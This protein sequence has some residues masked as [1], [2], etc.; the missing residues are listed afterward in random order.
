M[1]VADILAVVAG[2]FRG[3]K[4]CLCIGFLHIRAV[5]GELAHEVFALLKRQIA[6]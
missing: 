2:H 5:G 3:F 6:P 1:M 4:G